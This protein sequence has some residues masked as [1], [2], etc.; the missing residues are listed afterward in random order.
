MG[1][2]MGCMGRRL[3]D[4]SA[5]DG[6]AVKRGYPYHPYFW[7]TSLWSAAVYRLAL[8]LEI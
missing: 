3:Y 1:F 2:G 7:T 8:T 4:M 5:S 6:N